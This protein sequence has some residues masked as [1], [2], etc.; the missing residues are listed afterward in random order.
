MNTTTKL[1]KAIEDLASIAADTT[2]NPV[3]RFQAMVG[4][5]HFEDQQRLA[6]LPERQR[7]AAVQEA[8]DVHDRMLTLADQIGAAWPTG[9]TEG[10]DE[11]ASN[12][13]LAA[14]TDMVNRVLRLALDRADKAPIPPLGWFKFPRR[15]L[16]LKRLTKGQ[17][18]VIVSALAKTG[19]R[20][21]T[22]D[23]E[24]G[25]FFA[26]GEFIAGE[27]TWA[28]E[29]GVGRQV[30]R[31]TVAKLVRFGYLAAEPMEGDAT[32]FK[33]LLPEMSE[34]PNPPPPNPPHGGATPEDDGAFPWSENEPNPPPTHPQQ[35]STPD[36]DE[37]KEVGW[38]AT[39]PTKIKRG[40][41][42]SEAPESEQAPGAGGP[43][44]CD[45]G[46]APG[47]GIARADADTRCSVSSSFP[48]QLSTDA[49]ERASARVESP[50][51]RI[52]AA[53]WQAARLRMEDIGKGKDWWAAVPKD[54]GAS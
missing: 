35:G 40:G 9:W 24:R 16:Q 31:D 48:P 15:L 47:A 14:F 42:E 18:A 41:E 46:E 33:W 32:R 50:V 43:E 1:A 10:A 27:R 4:V 29:L 6:R 30:V 53:D 26:K 25:V 38:K 52:D 7:R 49:E 23:P 8:Y 44:Q 45:P 17:L 36:D 51:P 11:E 19:Y 34:Q 20:R 39:Q 22:W 3:R 13:A 21:R 12:A 54:G 28:A 2:V 5:L 37:G